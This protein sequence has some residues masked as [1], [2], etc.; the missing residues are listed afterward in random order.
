MSLNIEVDPPPSPCTAF[1][2]VDSAEVTVVGAAD[3]TTPVVDSAEV[4]T[5]LLDV[6][7]GFADV[8]RVVG[9]VT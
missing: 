1:V 5:T 4:L 8:E 9:M 3:E 2:D 7:V 6:V